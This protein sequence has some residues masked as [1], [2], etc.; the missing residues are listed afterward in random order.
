MVVTQIQEGFHLWRAIAELPGPM[1]DG[2][3]DLQRHPESE[4]RDEGSAFK[5]E[6]GMCKWHCIHFDT[7]NTLGIQ[8]FD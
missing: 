1:C 7:I 6:M 4:G 2:P 5:L 8:A 3:G